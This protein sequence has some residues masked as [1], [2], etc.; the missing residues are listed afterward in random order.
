MSR[1]LLKVRSLV[2]N[3][4][5]NTSGPNKEIDGAFEKEFG[6]ECERSQQSHKLKLVLRELEEGCCDVAR[7]TFVARA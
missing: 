4:V 3:A 1:G 7:Y 5:R 2:E 6:M